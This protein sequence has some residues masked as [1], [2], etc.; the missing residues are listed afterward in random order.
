[1][2]EILNQFSDVA[3]LLVQLVVATIF[4]SSGWRHLTDLETRAKRI[5]MPTWATAAVGGVELIAAVALILGVYPKIAAL[6][7]V[8]VMAGALYKKIF[9]WKVGY[10]SENGIG[11]HY[12]LLLLLAS[13]LIAATN[14]GVFALLYL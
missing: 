13:L 4:L 10:F 9:A 14:S 12:E 8:G 6:L 5:E 2:F 7:L 11:W 3:L 1:M